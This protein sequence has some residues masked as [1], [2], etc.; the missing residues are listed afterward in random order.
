M[1]MALK[2]QHKDTKFG[3]GDTVR[4]YQSISEGDKKRLQAF[5]GMVIAVR[6]TQASKSFVVRRIGSSQV[7]I[8]KIFPLLAPVVDNV[9][10]IRE[11][12]SG[13][14]QAKLYYTR[15]VS[16]REVE[17]I[18]QRK[19]KKDRAKLASQKKAKKQVKK[20]TAKRK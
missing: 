6:G 12:V 16:K 13:V 15:H 8:E 11:G 7:G 19:A 1:P 20:S 14:R 10:V 4:V 18:Y 2:L 17:K 9:E 5:E 3:V